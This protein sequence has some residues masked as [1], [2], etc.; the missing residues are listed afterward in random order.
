VNAG[1]LF[2]FLR[3]RGSYRPEPGW[4][5]F[6]C[7]LLVAL[8]VLAALLYALSGSPEPWLTAGPWQRTGRL[9]GIIAAG[10]AVYFAALYLLGF[11]L[12][13]F[14]RREG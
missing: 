3:K 7:K 2:W 13:D 14:A 11:R 1:L 8:G 9:A 6:L 5:L 4:F 10:M 12:A